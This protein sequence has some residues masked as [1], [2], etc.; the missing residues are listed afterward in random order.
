MYVPGADP[1]IFCG[2]RGGGKKEFKNFSK[3]PDENIKKKKK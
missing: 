2:V 1:Y 3:C